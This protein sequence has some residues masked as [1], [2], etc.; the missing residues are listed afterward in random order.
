ML[1]NEEELRANI[2]GKLKQWVNVIP[3][4]DKPII[5]VMSARMQ[6]ETFSPKDILDQV[7]RRTAVGDEL[8]QNWINLAVDHIMRSTLLR[9]DHHEQETG[10]RTGLANSGTGGL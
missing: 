3:D 5:G 6:R 7:Q 1:I 4:P 2:I 10:I 8:V 9:E